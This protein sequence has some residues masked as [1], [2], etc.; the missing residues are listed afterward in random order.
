MGGILMGATY[1]QWAV[2]TVDGRCV[3]SMG[4]CVIVIMLGYRRVFW[5]FSRRLDVISIWRRGYR[6]QWGE[7]GKIDGENEPRQL[8]W[9]VFRDAL[10]GPPTSWLPPRSSPSQIPLI[11]YE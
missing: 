5:V 2:H 1:C 3:W 11:E 6:H 7:N 9:F 4:V 10:D 8:S